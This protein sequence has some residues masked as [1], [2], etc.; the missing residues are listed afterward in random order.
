VSWHRTLAAPSARVAL[1]AALAACR[2][3]QPVEEA[4]T[5]HA[6]APGSA[7]GSSHETTDASDADASD[8][9]ARRPDG[10]ADTNVPAAASDIWIQRHQ[11]GVASLRRRGLRV[12]TLDPSDAHPG[13]GRFPARWRELDAV[14][15]RVGDGWR[16]PF[17][18]D[19]VA[20]TTLSW[21]SRGTDG[22]VMLVVTDEQLYVRTGHDN[23]TTNRLY[24]VASSSPERAAALARLV[25]GRRPP[26]FLADCGPSDP[27]SPDARSCRFRAAQ[28]ERADDGRDHLSVAT[29]N[30]QALLVLVN[31]ALPNGVAPFALPGASDLTEGPA[32]SAFG[33]E[34]D[35]WAR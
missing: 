9:D 24:W 3:S 23:P 29:K 27:A 2:S 15:L 21:F 25:A 14:L 5:V 10:A 7:E 6:H 18:E 17:A 34:L 8:A 11:A 22:R 20:G 35:E 32:I 13:R 31:R 30:V 26:A 33:E 4:R 28:A 19:L 16:G 12:A 1:F